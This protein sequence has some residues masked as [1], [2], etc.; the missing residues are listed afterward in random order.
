M[1]VEICVGLSSLRAVVSGAYALD[2]T[3]IS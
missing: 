2:F 1:I 3:A